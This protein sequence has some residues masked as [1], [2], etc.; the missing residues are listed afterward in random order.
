MF[1]TLTHLNNQVNN[2]IFGEAQKVI[3]KRS[4]NNYQ[5]KNKELLKSISHVSNEDLLVYI[6]ELE[7]DKLNLE[8]LRSNMSNELNKI[9]LEFANS[10]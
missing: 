5:Y 3:Q 9:K 6:L 2:A 1:K 7:I 4:S 8:N 10:K